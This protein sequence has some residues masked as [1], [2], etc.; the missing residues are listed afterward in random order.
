MID[1]I[2][3]SV[4]SCLGKNIIRHIYFIKKTTK[5]GKFNNVEI[6][7]RIEKFYNEQFK[8]WLEIDSYD[9]A[10]MEFY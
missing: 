7:T 2:L 4:A 8:C 6:Y 3:V 1:N 5:R 9:C 10:F